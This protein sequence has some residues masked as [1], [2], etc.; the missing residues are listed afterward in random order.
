MYHSVGLSEELA[1]F[2]FPTEPENKQFRLGQS[3]AV[4]QLS[5]HSETVQLRSNNTLQKQAW[6]RSWVV[7]AYLAYTRTSV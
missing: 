2:F 6:R 1:D 3:V 7:K 4:V 5:H